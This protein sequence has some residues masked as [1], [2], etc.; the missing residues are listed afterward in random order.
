MWLIDHMVAQCDSSTPTVMRLY[1]NGVSRRA[2]RDGTDAGNF[3]VAD[4]PSGL[5][6]RPTTSL[7]A[8]WTG[9]SAGATA[10]LTVQARVLTRP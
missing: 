7:V 10:I 2:I 8:Q 4:W 3:S 6:M 5:L 9:A 1:R